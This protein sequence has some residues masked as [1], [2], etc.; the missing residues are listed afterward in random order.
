M[1]TKGADKVYLWT[2]DIDRAVD[3]YRHVLGLPVVYRGG[4]DWVEF[5]AGTINL[6]LHGSSTNLPAP[7]G[8]TVVFEVDDVDAARLEL[9]ERGVEVT[10]E[11]EVEGHSRFVEFKD[12]D[13]NALSVIEYVRGREPS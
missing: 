13:G 4:S 6:A 12:P 9:R 8:A 5:S 1:N 10:H 7:G 2:A 11:S 3:F